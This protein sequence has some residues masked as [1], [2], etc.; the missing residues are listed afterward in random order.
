MNLRIAGL[1][2]FSD[3]GSNETELRRPTCLFVQ[4]ITGS[5]RHLRALL[6]R[7]PEEFFDLYKLDSYYYSIKI[8]DFN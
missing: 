3:V 8:F 4:V 2:A 5:A 1:P 7:N 6:R